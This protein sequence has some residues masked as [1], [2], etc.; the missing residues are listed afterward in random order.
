[1]FT[2]RSVVGIPLALA[3][4]VPGAW[5]AESKAPVARNDNFQD[6]MEIPV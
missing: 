1:M 6:R 5:T 4:I 2:E 3:L